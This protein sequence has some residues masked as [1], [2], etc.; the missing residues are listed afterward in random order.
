[1]L[2]STYFYF[3][4]RSNG[5]EPGGLSVSICREEAQHQR[6]IDLH[7]EQAVRRVPGR[8]RKALRQLE[9][10]NAR[11]KKL[12]ADR[13]TLFRAHRAWI[14]RR[15]ARSRTGV[16][17]VPLS[18]YA[19]VLSILVLPAAGLLAIGSPMQAGIKRLRA[20]RVIAMFRSLAGRSQ[21]GFA[22]RMYKNVL[23]NESD[24]VVAT[25]MKQ[26]AVSAWYCP[27][28][29]WP[30]FNKI[31]TPR[32][33][34]VPDI[35]LSEFPVGFAAK[36]GDPL[37]D[38][39]DDLDAAIQGGSHFVTYSE[40]VKWT[41][42]VDRYGRDPA[43]VHVVHHAPNALDEHIA[44][45]IAGDTTLATGEYCR[46]LLT[47]ALR[48]S[49]NNSYT[50]TFANRSFEYIFYASQFRPN[51]NIFNLLRAY[52]HLLR[53][54]FTGHKLILTGNIRIDPE[55]AGFIREHRLENDVV[56][57]H[58]LTLAE[59]AACYKLASIAVNPSF[60]EGGC[61]FTFTEA[62]SVGTPV[63]MARTAVASE[64]IT[65]RSLDKIMFFDPYDQMDMAGRME[66]AINNRG[67]LLNLQRPVYE[68]LTQRTWG[69]VVDEYIDILEAISSRPDG[70]QSVAAKPAAALTP[71]LVSR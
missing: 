53:R 31:K 38:S 55:I 18:L 65:E 26:T 9:A 12:V 2:I 10:K 62:L 33:M 54:R 39:F 28:A 43:A 67:Q 6:A 59:L 15:I 17:F 35:V 48:K 16:I 57:L 63:V 51:K 24:L 32:L 68:R 45:S 21:G 11:L 1:M 22:M 71:S 46:Q 40:Q 52:E 14:E 23:E 34:C 41:T 70:T 66:W 7:L 4:L 3:F 42:L 58:G 50:Q 36:G 64:V 29:F 69:T 30:A 60:S 20:L 27:T 13:V 37:F 49:S 5:A 47:A 61:P 8:R 56:C 44:I 25:A 19:I